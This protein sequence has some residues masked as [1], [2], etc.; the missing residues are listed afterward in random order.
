MTNL[1]SETEETMLS[2]NGITTVVSADSGDTD[3]INLEY[4]TISSGALTFAVQ[5]VTLNG[6]TP[7]PLTTPCAR[8]NRAYNTGS[9]AL[10]GPVYFYE[11]GTRTDANTHLI[12]PGGEQQT[13]KA[14]TAIS[15]NDY[16]I[17]TNIS[18]SV[19]EKTSAWVEFRLEAKPTTQSY[20]RPVSQHFAVSDASGTVE[21][22]KEP[23]LIIP[24]N[25]DVRLV[26]RAN[27]A[28]VDMAGGFSGYLASVI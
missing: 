5:E 26:A 25:Y 4:H 6:T 28:N 27:A 14:Q 11:G 8:A 20:W 12:I 3:T 17:I 21:L 24:S 19:I 10:T 23:F 1:G 16:W 13:E 2:T 15:D 9:S 18:G 7:V 22:L